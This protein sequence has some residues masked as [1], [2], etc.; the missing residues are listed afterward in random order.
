MIDARAFPR[1][2]GVVNSEVVRELAG[3]PLHAVAESDHGKIHRAQRRQGEDRHRVGVVEDCGLGRYAL[4]VRDDVKPR[5]PCPERLE[6]AAGA[7]R[8][9]DAL[10]DAISHRYV[11][12]EADVLQA[13]DL[14]RVDDVVGV[15]EDVKPFGRCIDTPRLSGQL[16][17][18]LD[19][20][21]RQV[22]PPRVDVDQREHAG[23]QSVDG[24]DVGD[25][26]P[27]ENSAARADQGHLRHGIHS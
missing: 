5:R 4:D 12:V 16:D 2:V 26:L 8:V 22:Q 9:P 24:E 25:Q 6:D 1:H 11:V 21:P 15:R 19:D 23:V 3:G 13:G 20:P 27:S 7:N 18:P 17:Q 14:D 10:V